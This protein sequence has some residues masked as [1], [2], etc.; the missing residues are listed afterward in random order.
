MPKRS[1]IE[2][3]DGNCWLIQ[4]ST[5]MRVRIDSSVKPALEEWMTENGTV[6]FDG[7]CFRQVSGDRY[8]LIEVLA[9]L[10][11][12]VDIAS[13]SNRHMIYPVNKDIFDLR[14]EN[15]SFINAWD[16]TDAKLLYDSE[17]NAVYDYGINVFLLLKDD[18]QM[19]RL[20]ARNCIRDMIVGLIKNGHII[21]KRPSN[22][23]VVACDL[24]GREQELARYVL[25]QMYNVPVFQ[26][27][28]NK[29]PIRYKDDD[30]LN[31]TV[32]NI[33]TSG[34]PANDTPNRLIRQSGD[35]AFLWLNDSLP[36]YTDCAEK[37]IPILKMPIWV[38]H[39]K[40]KDGRVAAMPRV[41]GKKTSISEAYLYQLRWAV[42]YY[43]ASDDYFSLAQALCKMSKEFEKQDLCI[44]HLDGNPRN[45]CLWNLACMSR[46]ENSVKGTLTTKIYDPFYWLSVNT[47]NGYRVICG[48]ELANPLRFFCPTN[49][50]YINLLCFFYTEG[51]GALCPPAQVDGGSRIGYDNSGT[52]TMAGARMIAYLQTAPAGLFQLY[53]KSEKIG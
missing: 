10:Y 1:V 24:N 33:D 40:A 31:L 22:R 21:Q 32:E 8:R 16:N 43:D 7:Y 2:N 20:D 13:L 34:V 37:M 35:K 25:A 53:A 9:G 4:E 5:G 41:T 23:H 28:R 49:A 14:Q 52:L 27:S 19:V 6:S 18:G 26:K 46:S 11:N 3:I 45:N 17:Y 29:K 15:I 38:W 42:A 30:C 50:N 48:T 39:R 44:D 12:G 51:F 47:E 36:D